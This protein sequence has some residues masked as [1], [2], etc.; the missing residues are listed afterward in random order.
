MSYFIL[1]FSIPLFIIT[2]S[3]SWY[4]SH[5]DTQNTYEYLSEEFALKQTQNLQGYLLYQNEL[6]NAWTIKEKLHYKDVRKIF[7]VLFILQL[8]SLFI[9]SRKYEN[10][11]RQKAILY[12]LFFLCSFSAIALSSFDYFWNNIFHNVLFSNSYWLMNPFDLSYYLF[13]NEFFLDTSSAIVIFSVLLH[14]FS[15]IFVRLFSKV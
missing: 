11:I 7:T 5:Y 10:K 3:T 1:F 8:V 12:S 15:L 6:N 9:I 14:L 4:V 13:T 2:F